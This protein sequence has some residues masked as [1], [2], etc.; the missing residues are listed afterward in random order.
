MSEVITYYAVI[1]QFSTFDKPFGVIRR[2]E[3]EGGHRDELFSPERT[4]KH[5]SLLYSAEHGDLAHDMV[6][7]SAAEATRILGRLAACAAGPRSG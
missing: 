3:N 1:D 4:W 2:I 7:I 5:T 6:L